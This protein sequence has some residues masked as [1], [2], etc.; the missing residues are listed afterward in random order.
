M[1]FLSILSPRKLKRET[2][3]NSEILFKSLELLV[4]LFLSSLKSK[5]GIEGALE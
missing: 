1:V 5:L 4:R 2:K 3:D